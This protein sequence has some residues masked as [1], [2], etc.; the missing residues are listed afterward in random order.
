[1]QGERADAVI[2]SPPFVGSTRFYLAN[3]IRL[4]FCGWEP[5]D[6]Q[7]S[8]RPSAFLEVQQRRSREVYASFFEVVSRTLR[9]G[10][11]AILH[12]G[13]TERCDMGEELA[14]LAR[15]RFSVLGLFR[16]S[17]AHCQKHGVRDQGATREHELL[18]LEL[19]RS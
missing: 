14:L 6:F 15:E 3:W 9:P 16:E 5:D 10:G 19:G 17:V 1:M 18:F 11:L 12:L 13:A 8:A 4:W 2:S 7:E